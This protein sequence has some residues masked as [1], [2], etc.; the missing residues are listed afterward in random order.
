MSKHRSGLSGGGE[1]RGE[2]TG[3]RRAVSQLS[4]ADL[5]SASRG[6]VK[7][8]QRLAHSVRKSSVMTT[9][10]FHHWCK[11]K[12]KKTLWLRSQSRCIVLRPSSHDFILKLPKQSSMG[13]TLCLLFGCLSVCLVCLFFLLNVSLNMLLLLLGCKITIISGCGYSFRCGTSTSVCSVL[14]QHAHLS[15]RRG[16]GRQK[17]GRGKLPVRRADK[18]NRL[19]V[20]WHGPVLG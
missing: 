7:E 4:D 11:K 6:V 18:P 17:G 15:W 16:G 2:F 8:R 20:F 12:K 14:P 19:K 13:L 1:D 10:Q 5:R 3:N 9:D